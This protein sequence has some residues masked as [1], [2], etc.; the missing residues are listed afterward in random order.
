VEEDVVVVVAAVRSA[1]AKLLRIEEARVAVAK[2]FPRIPGDKA[3]RTFS[4]AGDVVVVTAADGSQ[5]ATL[6]TPS[7]ARLAL[8]EGL[9]FSSVVLVL[10]E[11]DIVVATAAAA[12][13]WLMLPRK[14][15]VVV[16][17][18]EEANGGSAALQEVTEAALGSAVDHD[19]TATAPGRLARAA[20][21]SSFQSSR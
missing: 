14:E 18:E 16:V 1:K 7:D 15:E 5:T 2:S 17:V 6:A 8:P 11:A 20:G 13:T 12:T 9:A 21:Q 19:A 4:A 10:Q 3:G